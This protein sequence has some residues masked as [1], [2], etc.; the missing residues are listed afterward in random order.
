[1]QAPVLEI[2]P[3]QVESQAADPTQVGQVSSALA[4]TVFFVVCRHLTHLLVFALQAVFAVSGSQVA[5]TQSVIATST[6]LLFALGGVISW[7][8]LG[9][10]VHLAELASH[11]AVLAVIVQLPF[12]QSRMRAEMSTHTSSLEPLAP[13]VTF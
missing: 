6:H 10:S 12:E 11:N 3:V 5:S 9:H 4:V 13:L 8:V 2:V 7:C 1:M